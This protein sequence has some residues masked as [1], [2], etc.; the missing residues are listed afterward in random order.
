MSAG[1][2][3]N[4]LCGEVGR[5]GQGSQGRSEPAALAQTCPLRPSRPVPPLLPAPSSLPSK[6]WCFSFF[7]VS[8]A[9]RPSLLPFPSPRRDPNREEVGPPHPSPPPGSHSLRY[10][11]TAVSRPGRGEPRFIAVGYVDDTQFVRFD[12]DAPDPRMEPRARW[13]EQEG[14]EYWDRNT[15]RVKDAAQTFRVNLNTLRGYY[16]QS[17]AGER[18]GRVRVMAPI[19][20]DRR[21]RPDSAGPRVTPA[22]RDTP[23]LRP[24][25][26]SRGLEPVSFQFGFNHRGWSGRVRV[27]HR[28][29]DV[30]L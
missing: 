4:G 12:S 27:S 16:N 20:R 21:G 10:F 26:S 24:R 15:R 3:G 2:G 29:G 9:P 6:S 22:L 5:T 1:S 18:H 14:P 25:R 19:P 13:V 17:E 28:P 23:D 7:S 8:R 30:R 11:L